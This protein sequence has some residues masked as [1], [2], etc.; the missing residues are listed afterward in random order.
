MFPKTGRRIP[1][2]GNGGK[3]SYAS[4][5]ADILRQELGSSHQALKTLMRWNGANERTAKNWLA[6]SNGPSAEHLLQLIRNSDPVFDCVLRLADR[7]AALSNRQLT[8]IRDALQ[9]AAKFLSE[10]IEKPESPL[11]H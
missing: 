1:G 9:A 8:E 4:L 2:G 6:G 10:V 7:K 3:E 11:K 5:I